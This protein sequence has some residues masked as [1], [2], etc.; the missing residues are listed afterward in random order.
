MNTFRR[1]LVPARIL[2]AE[3]MYS[4]AELDIRRAIAR[5][6]T[7]LEDEARTENPTN[8]PS[9]TTRLDQLSEVR[10]S[11]GKFRLKQ[12]AS[13]KQTPPAKYCYPDDRGDL[14]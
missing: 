2:E 10:R 3:E 9:I 8:L 6:T 5:L 4:E 1:T 13:W 7:L 11:L 12:E 14:I